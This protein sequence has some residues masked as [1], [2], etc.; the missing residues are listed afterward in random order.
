[1]DA[2]GRTVALV[3]QKLRA[4]FAGTLVTLTVIE[5]DR[6]RRGTAVGSV[7]SR[8]SEAALAGAREME[9][10]AKTPAEKED[11]RRAL[12]LA[13]RNLIHAT[14][15]APV[16]G[17]VLSH[18]AAAGDRVTEDQE[19]LTLAEA[20][21]VVFV[22]DVPQSALSQIRPGLEASVTL[23]GRA[24]PAAGTVHNLL[25]LAN[26]TDFTAP[27]RI[28]LAGDAS[29][30]SLGLFGTSRIVIAR[31]A[32]AVVVPDAALLRDDVTG[33]TR[34]A[35]V[36]DGHARWH[37]AVT[38]LRGS[39]GTEILEPPLAPGDAVIVGGQVGLPEG[40]AVAVQP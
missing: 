3:Q 39:A 10:E 40:A 5:G 12:A 16:D 24:K 19:I 36:Q 27:V 23:A 34:I 13:E 18:A 11:A 32:G 8:D 25:P 14:L 6:V 20:G 15:R 2:P 30:S 31:K 21:A 7:L 37:E 22:A 35:L 26:A 33:K 28:D 4:P 9:R 1:M 38:G 17:V 29:P